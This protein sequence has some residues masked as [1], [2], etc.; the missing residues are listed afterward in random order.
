M[1]RISK[2]VI[3][4]VL[5]RAA[6]ADS[7]ELGAWCRLVDGSESLLLPEARTIELHHR[8]ARAMGGSKGRKLDT[9]SNLLAL[10]RVCHAWVHAYPT[11]ARAY[12]FIVSQYEE[13]P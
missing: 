4:E 3:E 9:A 2:C 12:G 1:S 13:T 6:A 10:H 7:C 5:Q 8:Q 11:M